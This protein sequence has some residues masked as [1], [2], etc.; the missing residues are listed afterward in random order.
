MKRSIDLPAGLWHRVDQMAKHVE[1]EPTDLIE[2]CLVRRIR[3]MENYHIDRI[4]VEK[5]RHANNPK[6]GKSK[7]TAKTRK[8]RLGKRLRTRKL[9][10]VA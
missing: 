2:H 4:Q 8:E 5:S 3:V 6:G 10:A 7:I 1:V 9:R